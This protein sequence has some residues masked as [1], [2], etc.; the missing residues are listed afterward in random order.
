MLLR[1]KIKLEVEWPLSLKEV[2][3]PGELLGFARHLV[4]VWADARA[5]GL[6]NFITIVFADFLVLWLSDPKAL[7]GFGK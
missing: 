6:V 7:A 4:A 3:N 2:S 5:V 1:E